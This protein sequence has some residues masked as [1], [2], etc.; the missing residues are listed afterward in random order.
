MRPTAA[1]L[2]RAATAAAQPR[3][4][5]FLAA[6]RQPREPC[7]FQACRA[8]AT[9]SSSSGALAPSAATAEEPPQT[10]LF[11]LLDLD[12]DGRLTG[13]EV[14]ACLDVLYTRDKACHSVLAPILLK[15]AWQDSDVVSFSQA[16]S[17]EET[18]SQSEP[19]AAADNGR[20]GS[21]GPIELDNWSLTFESEGYSDFWDGFEGWFA[22]HVERA[23]EVLGQE[24]N[25][26]KLR[27]RA[28]LRHAPRLVP[29]LVDEFKK[30]EVIG[31]RG[32]HRYEACPEGYTVV[33]VLGKG[34]FA[35]VLLVKNMASE[36]LQAMKR[37]DRT[38]IGKALGVS[39]EQV[40]R[41][42]EH[43]FRHLQ[44]TSHPHLVKLFDFCQDR[45][46]TCFIM[47]TADGGTLQG[48]VDKAYGLRQHSLAMPNLLSGSLGAMQ[49]S[50]RYVA[51]V[52]HQ[53]AYALEHLHRDF[54]IHKD[55]KLENLMLMSPAG[56]PHVVLI[57]F[58]TTEMLSEGAEEGKVPAPAGTPHTMAPEVIDTHLGLRPRG[59]D[60]RCDIYSLGVVA[61]ELLTGRPPYEPVYEDGRLSSVID[62]VATR[63]RLVEADPAGALLDFGR[64]E[65]CAEFVGQML[66]LD[67]EE[68]PSAHE[69]MRHPWMVQHAERRRQRTARS[70][71][72]RAL[73]EGTI[74]G[75][76]VEEVMQA[77]IE[78]LQSRR[79]AVALA[80]LE[81][82]KKP[83]TQRITAYHMMLHVPMNRLQRVAE[84]FRRINKGLDG[85]IS[86]DE[87]ETELGEVLGI[88]RS[89]AHDVVVAVDVE[90]SGSVGFTA[91]GAACVS[92]TPERARALLGWAFE[93][94][95]AAGPEGR[96]RELDVDT[97]R[98]ILSH[99][100]GG[101]LQWAHVSPWLRH[102][103]QVL[104]SR[105]EGH[106]GRARSTTP[107]S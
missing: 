12:G 54:R 104:D 100:A 61:C 20:R 5:A 71:G 76:S 103:L 29:A 36:S 101:R 57:D 11:R 38:R 96:A 77:G 90:G 107:E 34:A 83:E 31:V 69:C 1:C 6:G 25:R 33:D 92:V 56:R 47:D 64:S 55:V 81:F 35:T 22:P 66:A 3:P 102:A 99:A 88:S 39:D 79:E 13:R 17:Q 50:E 44:H 91:F 89:E 59:F 70:D 68:R 84:G 30:Q 65:E 97:A 67:P 26:R 18:S 80:M 105:M 37:V 62:Y 23:V 87:M 40:S 4:A 72:R 15:A 10:R 28:F 8:A 52:L 49:L 45:R 9:A 95:E 2:R 93:A 16:F 82:S 106:E 27:Q 73:R 32:L 48:L 24:R 7:V 42:V 75:K 53:A 14:R 63:A 98:A 78:A 58:G 94:L 43:E 51:D 85:E 60:E 41:M 86:Y 19:S 74:T 21:L 46:Y